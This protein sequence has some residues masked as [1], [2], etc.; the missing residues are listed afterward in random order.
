MICPQCNDDCWRDEV[1]IGVGVQCGPWCCQSCGWYEGHEIDA[2]IDAEQEET[3]M[4]I[5][6]FNGRQVKISHNPQA[7]KPW[8]AKFASRFESDPQWL[9]DLEGHGANPDTAYDN[10]VLSL[11]VRTFTAS[12]WMT[13]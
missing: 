6:D 2:L 8:I 10:L 3:H 13:I 4:V 7:D 9:E 5:R 11:E 12:N 1:D